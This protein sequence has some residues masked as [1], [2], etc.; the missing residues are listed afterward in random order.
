M[1]KQ[2]SGKRD[3]MTWNE[4]FLDLESTISEYQKALKMISKASNDTHET[5]HLRE[6]ALDAL[7]H[8][9]NAELYNG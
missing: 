8:K 4:I 3:R 1:S 7:K 9:N 5:S 6:I 2:L